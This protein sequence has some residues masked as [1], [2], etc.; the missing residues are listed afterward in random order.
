MRYSKKVL[1][2]GL[3]II[4]VPRHDS[5]AVTVLIMVK[6]G[7]RY[8]T[9]STNGL[10]HFVEHMMFKGT[11]NRPTTL[12]ISKDLDR[13]G[14]EYNAFTSKDHTG[15]YIKINK[16]KISLALDILSDMLQRSKLDAEE[17]EREKGVITE[18][19]NMYE[20]NPMLYIED[21]LEETIFGSNDSLGR[22]IIG[23]RKNIR[24]F[25]RNEFVKY[26]SEYYTANRTVIVVSGPIN[27]DINKKVANL[28]SELKR[29]KGQKTFKNRI[30][31][32]S[33]TRT[34]IVTKKSEQVQLCLGFP[35]YSYQDQERYSQ[36]LLAVILGGNMSSR[37][38][39]S[40]RERQGLAYYIKA[41]MNLYE[42][43]GIF[44]IQAG[45]DKARL[46]QAITGILIEL[47][48]IKESGVSNEE[49]KNAREFLKGKNTLQLE[50]SGNIASFIGRQALL[51][52]RI[53]SPN[54][55]DQQLRKV[56]PIKI[57]QVAEKLFTQQKANLVMIGPVKANPIYKKMI[58][59]HI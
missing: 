18:E 47:A 42:D 16:D 5:Q 38:F 3:S 19:I 27:K 28:F 45:L 35:S 24:K 37:L 39:I 13:V 14:A 9:Q 34:G 49:V 10:S 58:G 50:D 46:K 22:L 48:L 41:D 53:M 57:S 31:R 17:I 52:N 54:E 30:N 23:P 56:N 15:Y 2:N 4:T 11:P 8:E 21:V 33:Q 7:S 36:A 12:D 44:Y 59:R 40:I 26:L 29:G 1:S 55:I 32:Q 20:D 43:S 51:Q 6:A 25:K